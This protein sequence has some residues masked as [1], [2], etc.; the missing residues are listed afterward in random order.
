MDIVEKLPSPARDLLGT[1]P[2]RVIRAILPYAL[3][4]PIAETFY[5]YLKF[6]FQPAPDVNPIFKKLEAWSGLSWVEP[7]FRFFTGGMEA[8]AMVLLFIPG[9]QLA[10]ALLTMALM[11]GAVLLHGVGPI[12]IEGFFGKLFEE[13]IVAWFLAAG[14]VFLRRRE[15]LPFLRG[16]ATDRRAVRLFARYA[17]KNSPTDPEIRG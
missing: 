3:A 15:I 5:K 6:K 9:L 8:L 7:D 13:A 12:G 14:I 1:K 10:G 2:A 17:R 16:L 11:S 4:L